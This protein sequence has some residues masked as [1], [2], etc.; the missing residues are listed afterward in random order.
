MGTVKSIIKKEIDRIKIFQSFFLEG[1]VEFSVE[2][3]L[4]PPPLSFDS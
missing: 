1:E 4:E 2:A 3:G